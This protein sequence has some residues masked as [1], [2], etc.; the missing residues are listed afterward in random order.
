MWPHGRGD[1]GKIRVV[2]IQGHVTGV[3]QQKLRM[4]QMNSDFLLRRGSTEKAIRAP[5]L[6]LQP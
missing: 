6:L 3:E 2:L 1:L 4:S 5:R